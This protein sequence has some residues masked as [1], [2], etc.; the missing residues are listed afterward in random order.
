MIEDILN[1]AEYIYSSTYKWSLKRHICDVEYYTES[2]L[3]DLDFTICSIVNT[4]KNGV[5]DKISLGILLGFSL[6]DNSPEQYYDKCEE[7]LFNDLLS[8][9]EKNHLID[10]DNATGTISITKL[11]QISLKS[12][13]LYRFHKGC[14]CIYEHKNISY[15]YPTALMMFPFYMD[16]GI[17]TELN[18]TGQIWPADDDMP[19]IFARKIDFGERVRQ[20]KLTV[21]LGADFLVSLRNKNVTLDA[22][23]DLHLVVPGVGILRECGSGGRCQ[24]SADRQ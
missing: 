4:G 10:I 17:Y 2:E 7:Q 21:I 23:A 3:P 12:N 1:N 6:L 19:A 13:K 8:I 16:M 18:D 9:V 20:G 11:G 15:P 14:Q 5:Y 24:A 22:S